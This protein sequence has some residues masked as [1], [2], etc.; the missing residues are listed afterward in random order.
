MRRLSLNAV[1]RLSSS[2]S[3]P[4]GNK[5][6]AL[7]AGGVVFVSAIA[8]YDYMQRKERERLEVIRIK[9]EEERRAEEERKR[10]EASARKMYSREEVSKHNTV[11][12]GI[13]VSYKNGVY[14][15]SSDFLF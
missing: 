15:T 13:W 4:A 10:K 12:T 3:K 11:E 1:R 14:G 6:A 8:G 5:R 2:S 7:V 9:E